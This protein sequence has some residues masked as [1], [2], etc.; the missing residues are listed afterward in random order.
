MNYEE[1]T[2][3]INNKISQNAKLV[4]FPYFEVMVKL[5]RTENNLND[6]L[7]TSR[8]ILELLNYNVYFTGAKYCYNNEITIVKENELLVAIKDN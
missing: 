2:S 8:E 7:L 1:I 3:Y 6:F 5:N 4:V